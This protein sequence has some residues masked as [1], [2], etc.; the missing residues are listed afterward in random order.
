MSQD[1]HEAYLQRAYALDSGNVS[2]AR[3][4]YNEWAKDY[5]SDLAKHDYASPQ[6]AVE[7]LLKYWPAP[8]DKDNVVE[9]LDAGCGTGL[10]ASE[11]VKAKGQNGWKI[12]GVDLTQGMLD[13]A[14]TKNLYRNLWTVDLNEKIEGVEDG[15]YDAV[16]CV[17]T[18]TKGHVG[19]GC[20]GEFVRVGKVVIATIHDEIFES[21]G[22]KKEIERLE[23][24]GRVEI[25]STE[26][27]G[28]MKGQSSGGRMVVLRRK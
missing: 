8:S 27:F 21:L 9:I 11:L 16:L 17:G 1:Q 19:S 13:V 23:S 18:L 5:D 22:Y 7:T 6:V 12:D 15:K 26:Q 3:N 25:L 28:I 2:T 4:L 10:V 20:L 24:E 14:A